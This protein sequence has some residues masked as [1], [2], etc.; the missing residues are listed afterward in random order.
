MAQ[1][2][3]RID[4]QRYSVAREK[5]W[6]SFVEN[7]ING[8]WNHTR[9]FL[10]YHA[11]GRFEDESLLFFEDNRLRAVLPAA[12]IFEHDE[13][14][15]PRRCL[16]SHPGATYG[17]PVFDAKMSYPRVMSVFCALIQY[18][19]AR[20]YHKIWMR[21]AEPVFFSRRCGEIDVALLQHGFTLLGREL[22][23]AVPLEHLTEDSAI[24]VFQNRARS[25]TN[26]ARNAGVIAR[27]TNDFDQYWELLETNL[28]RHRVQPT[29]RLSEIRR[30]HA[31]AP[32][33]VLLVGAYHQGTL[34]SGTLLFIMNSVAAHTM[35]M[36]QNYEHC[37]LRSLNLAIHQALIEC[38]K[39]NLRWLNFGISSVPGS[40]GLE[41]NDGLLDFKRRCGGEGVTRDL[42]ELTL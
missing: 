28:Q 8:T 34:I 16:R 18:A 24:G 2:D 33:R 6:D 22:S 15:P 13:A 29:H 42:F 23:S 38:V 31:L 3:P 41:M 14:G 39:R 1:A 26:K 21:I 9:Q 37:Q 12:C 5:E 10:S 36:A 40:L 11:K 32:E 27:L 19:R 30:L 7:A 25:T 35:Y 17:G 20:D 4:V